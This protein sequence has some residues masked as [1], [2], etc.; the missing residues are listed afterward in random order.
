MKKSEKWQAENVENNQSENFDA[1]NEEKR[2]KAVNRELLS[3]G[4]VLLRNFII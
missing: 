2:E 1:Q 4:K 3:L